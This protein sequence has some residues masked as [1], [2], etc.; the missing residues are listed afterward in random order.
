MIVELLAISVP[1]TAQLVASHAP[2]QRAEFLKDRR[3]VQNPDGTG[4]ITYNDQL[5]HVR[6]DTLES[7][8]TRT[9]FDSHDQEED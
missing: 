6:R 8:E 3:G 9:G 4:F 1:R 2:L 5:L 7:A